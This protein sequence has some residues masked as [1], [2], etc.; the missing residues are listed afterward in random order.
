MSFGL[1]KYSNVHFIFYSICLLSR[2]IQGIA[3]G[4]T[5]TILYSVAS[6]YKNK[7]VVNRN[8]ALMETFGN[9]GNVCGPI[10]GSFLASRFEYSVAFYMLAGLKLI[11][12]SSSLFLKASVK[13]ESNVSFIK[14]LFRMR[15]FLIFILVISNLSTA[16]FYA[17]VLANHLINK[18][19]MSLEK[20]SF[21]LAIQ[22]ST[23]LLFAN[24]IPKISSLFGMKM[25]LCLSPF[26]NMF[27]A[28]MLN[29]SGFLNQNY[30]FTIC[31]LVAFGMAEGL[32]TILS[33]DE[34]IETIKTEY[35]ITNGTQNDLGSAIYTLGVNLGDCLGPI[36]G[37]FL[38]DKFNFEVCCYMVST[39][40]LIIFLI[41][42]IASFNE[43]RRTCCQK[44]TDE[45]KIIDDIMSCSVDTLAMP[46]TRDSK[47]KKQI[48]ELQDEDIPSSIQTEKVEGRELIKEGFS[49]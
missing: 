36:I 33:V 44:Q 32:V 45:D 48:E 20:A 13:G 17:P 29:P 6:N 31:A 16:N 35:N 5:V 8:I 38:T 10:I 21:F 28:L 19:N 46:L 18:Y 47:N 39:Q 34:F 9:L 41:F 26:L 7:N 14:I 4:I 27:F 2:L 11:F 15:I 49:P 43:I 22:G 12:I 37:G 24:L 1:S 25:T 3:A 42:F 23:Y 30:I 40:N